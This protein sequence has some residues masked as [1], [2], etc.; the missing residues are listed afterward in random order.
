MPTCGRTLIILVPTLRGCGSTHTRTPQNPLHPKHPA[1]A[2]VVGDSLVVVGVPLTRMRPWRARACAHHRRRGAQR[3]AQRETPPP[4]SREPGAPAR[5]RIVP[6]GSSWAL[7]PPEPPPLGGLSPLSGAAK[8]PAE[9]RPRS[10]ISISGPFVL[11]GTKPAPSGS[12]S[13]SS[14][15]TKHPRLVRAFP[16]P[17]PARALSLLLALALLLLLALLAAL[18]PTPPPTGMAAAAAAAAARRRRAPGRGCRRRAREARSSG[19]GGGAAVAA[20]AAAAAAARRA[21]RRRL[22]GTT[23]R[24]RCCCWWRPA[25]GSG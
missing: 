25:R 10:A 7:P 15:L 16:R 4:G 6:L 12:L 2:A 18:L 21:R 24:Q 9:R 5:L 19:G 8:T 1:G 20:A 13:L 17:A 14:P 11:I 23:R 22:R 3:H